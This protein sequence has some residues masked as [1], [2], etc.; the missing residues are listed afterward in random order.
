M[1]PAPNQVLA[2]RT[3]V[4]PENA[5][6]TPAIW[7]VASHLCLSR[8]F[9]LWQVFPGPPQAFWVPL[10][11]PS[12]HLVKWPPGSAL[13]LITVWSTLSMALARTQC[14]LLSSWCCHLLGDPP[15]RW[16]RVSRA[17]SPSLVLSISHFVWLAFWRES[18]MLC[19]PRALCGS[20]DLQGRFNVYRGWGR[21]GLSGQH[22]S[23]L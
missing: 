12:D 17:R 23:L 14:V 22:S 8:Y 20:Q 11:I 16:T 19:W 9:F 2:L 7:L 10:C 18:P 1:S 5:L 4:S 15:Q 6:R 3:P 13:S 21:G